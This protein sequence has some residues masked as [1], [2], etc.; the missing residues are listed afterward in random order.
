MAQVELR[1]VKPIRVAMLRA[2]LDSFHDQK[3]VWGEL[4]TFI[5]GQGLA[6]RGPTIAKY[7]SMEPI[8]LAV[9]SPLDPTDLVESHDRIVVEDLEE[10]FMAVYKHIGAMCD[11]TVAYEALFPW[12]AASEYEQAGPSREVYIK[13]PMRADVENGDWDNIIVEVQVPV[14]RKAT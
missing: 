12:L 3:G 13:V 2:S 10:A 8:E 9:C 1:T 6:P 4:L 7:F 11:I 5:F 14:K